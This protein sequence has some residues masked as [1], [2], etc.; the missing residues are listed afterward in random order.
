MSVLSGSSCQEAPVNRYLAR[1][2]SFSCD[3]PITLPLAAISD[4]GADKITVT[5]IERCV[6]TGLL[7]C[8]IGKGS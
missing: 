3:V 6:L 7:D 4:R 5:V 8:P 1:L 2:S